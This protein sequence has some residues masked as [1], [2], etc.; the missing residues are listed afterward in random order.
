MLMPNHFHLLLETTDRKLSEAMQVLLTRYARYF[1]RKYQ[2]VGHLFQ[3]RYKAILCQKDTYLLELVRYIHLNPV[4]AGLAEDPIEW[5]WSSYA[6]YL[7]ERDS[8]WVRTKEVLEY[9][10]KDL[11]PARRKFVSFM[12][13]S[14]NLEHR[15]EFYQVKDGRLLGEEEFI[16]EIKRKVCEPVRKDRRVNIGKVSFSELA[17]RISAELKIDKELLRTSGKQR[18]G[19]LAR[20]I[21]G[22]VGR[23][24]RHW[25]TGEIA[26]FL[27]RDL[28]SISKGISRFE[29]RLSNDK[30]IQHLVERIVEKISPQENAKC[31]A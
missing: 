25:K 20:G 4:R 28:T 16:E 11:V 12:K 1:N 24:Y 22:Y 29:E 6:A 13:E 10:S 26:R 7:G 17:E 23:K 5:D 3:G 27:G 9:F 15:L 14:K 31:Q 30:E 18:Q 8:D 19:S 21:F 2:R